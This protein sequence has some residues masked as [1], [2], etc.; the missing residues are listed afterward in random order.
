M[1]VSTG[2]AQSFKPSLNRYVLGGIVIS[3]SVGF[4]SL[5][6]AEDALPGY[7]I[8]VHGIKGSSL[9]IGAEAIS[10][11]AQA[12][13]FAAKK[14]DFAF[15]TTHNEAFI[16]ETRQLIADISALLQSIEAETPK[17]EKAAP[18]AALLD[19]L[20]DACAAYDIDGVDKAMTELESFAYASDAELVPWLR[21]QV[22]IMGFKQIRERLVQWKAQVGK[23]V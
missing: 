21:E 2:I 16:Q 5:I 17:P 11:Q 9:G 13:E 15:V 18:E 6:C 8:V 12:L 1:A 19:A 23:E 22:N 4:D 10:L 20:L 7:A 3:A 14:N